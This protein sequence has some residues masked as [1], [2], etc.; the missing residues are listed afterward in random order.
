VKRLKFL[1]L[2]VA[3]AT[4][5]TLGGLAQSEQGT[6]VVY[7]SAVCWIRLNV[8]P[9]V[10]L[11]TIDATSFDV[12]YLEKGGGPVSVRTNCKGYT[13]NAE[14]TDVSFPTGFDGGIG[15]GTAAILQDF[16][17]KVA[18]VTGNPYNVQDTY[19]NFTALNTPK[20]VGEADNPATHAFGMQYKY[21]IDIYDIPGDYSVT[22]RYTAT[23]K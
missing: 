12:G 3:L 16:Y 19:T 6:T 20:L 21:M 13:L 18:T 22:I 14:A 15:D 7:W 4:L 5:V 2:A 9:D 23:A 8:H 11:G 1:A 10:N 17:W